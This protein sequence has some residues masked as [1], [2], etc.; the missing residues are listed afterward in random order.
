MARDVEVI[1]HQDAPK[2][3]W[4]PYAPGLKVNKGKILFI[5]G[6]TAAPVY[7]SH[8]HIPEEFDS[9]P[10][11]MGEQTRISFENIKKT[12][13]AAGGTMDD[14]VDVSRFIVRMDEQDM[15]NAAQKEFFPSHS[16]SSTT[17]GVTC[18]ATDPRCKIEVRAIAVLDDET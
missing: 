15:A 18:L 2:D 6:C 11:D 4:M 9:I 16:P 5:A 14:I 12:V 7:H 10:E 13:E 17:V 1:H 3:V 8:P